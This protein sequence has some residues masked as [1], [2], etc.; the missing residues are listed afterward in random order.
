MFAV[1][2]DVSV[3]RIALSLLVALIAAA[4]AGHGAS[5]QDISQRG[6]S[7]VTGGPQ[8]R[9]QAPSPASALPGEN[10]GSDRVIPAEH[11][12]A[13]MSPTESLFDAVVRGDL[14]AARDAIARGADFTAH[15][16][17]GQTP[18]D[19]SIDLGRNNIT[20]MLLSM[21]VGPSDSATAAAPQ[22]KAAAAASVKPQAKQVSAPA[23]TAPIAKPTPAPAQATA[24]PASNNPGVPNPQR[25]FLGFGG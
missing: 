2:I 24:A 3:R 5:A 15:N 4:S 14:A 12:A 11:S 21:R 19:E 23:S 20:F 10:A 25:G 9:K 13:D 8:A 1:T 22:A 16:E 7:P 6:M 17:L 18:L